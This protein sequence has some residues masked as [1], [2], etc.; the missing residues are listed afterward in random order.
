MESSNELMSP[1]GGEADRER[2]ERVE[3]Y[4]SRTAGFAGLVKKRAIVFGVDAA[5]SDTVS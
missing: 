1:K 3:T 5:T 2:R 4:V